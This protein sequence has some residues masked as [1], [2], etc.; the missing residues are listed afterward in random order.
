MSRSTLA[1]WPLGPCH[2]CCPGRI[3]S[4]PDPAVFALD[5]RSLNCPAPSNYFSSNTNLT[6]AWVSSSAAPGSV[7]KPLRSRS[8]LAWPNSRSGPRHTSPARR[9]PCECSATRPRSR[10]G[11]EIDRRLSPAPRS[12][13]AIKVFLAFHLKACFLPMCYLASSA[14]CSCLVAAPHSPSPGRRWP[15]S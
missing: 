2:R 7:L 6:G 9:P 8:R 12:A 1:V 10:G 5:S 11:F 4:R 3:P 13:M 14:K 15:S